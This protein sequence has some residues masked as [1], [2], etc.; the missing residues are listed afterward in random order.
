MPPRKISTTPAENPPSKR[1]QKDSVGGAVGRKRSVTPRRSSSSKRRTSVPRSK[2][3]EPPADKVNQ[4]VGKGDIS[5]RERRTIGLRRPS[6]VQKSRPHTDL[7]SYQS[8]GLLDNTVFVIFLA[9]IS[10]FCM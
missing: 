2:L 1:T 9:V 6:E 7:K 3:S 5:T 4:S 10:V 8:E